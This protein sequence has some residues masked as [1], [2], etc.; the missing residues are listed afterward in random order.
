MDFQDFTFIGEPSRRH[1][2]LA[3]TKEILPVCPCLCE[4]PGKRRKTGDVLCRCPCHGKGPR[5]TVSLC[6]QEPLLRWNVIRKPGSRPTCQACHAYACKP[7][8]PP[9]PLCGVCCPFIRANKPVTCDVP[10]HEG[11]HAGL[12]A[13]GFAG[14]PAKRVSW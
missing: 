14:P 8:P 6:G 4:S 12:H 5:F 3:H 7:P 13:G 2:H 11:A 9:P 10:L 1:V